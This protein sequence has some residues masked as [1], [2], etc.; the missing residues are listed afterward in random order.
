MKISSVLLYIFI[1]SIT[2]LVAVNLF[3][4]QKWFVELVEDCRYVG[5]I[6]FHDQYSNQTKIKQLSFVVSAI[7]F[8]SFLVVRFIA[9]K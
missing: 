7:S 4:D 2:V 1:F 5:D 9:K 6:C 3:G 8:V